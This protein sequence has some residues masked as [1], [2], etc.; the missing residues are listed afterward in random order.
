MFDLLKRFRPILVT[1]FFIFL[2]FLILVMSAREG[3][4]ASWVER[5]LWRVSSPVQQPITAAILWV[6]GVGTR[7]FFLTGV[8]EENEALR[9]KISELQE[10][11]HRLRE[12]LLTADRVQR[13]MALQSENSLTGTVARVF[14]RDPSNFFKTLL[15]NKGE[16]EGIAK[17]MVVLTADGV[18][19]RVI[20]VSATVAKVLQITDPNSAVDVMIQ[21]SRCQGIMEGKREDLCVL[22]YIQKNEDVQ[23]GDLVMTSGLG[24]IFPKGLRVGTVTHVDRKRPGIFQH[25]EV[26]PSVDFSRL[27]E[28]LIAGEE[29]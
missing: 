6:R 9:R 26:K 20:E 5:L 15:V 28:V 11:N 22:K 10:E 18:V 21:R 19:G 2:A 25:I 23:V 14:A 3:R 13:L 27:E 1:L 7:Y 29:P 12:A 17:D 8:Q 4:E 24:G 16:D